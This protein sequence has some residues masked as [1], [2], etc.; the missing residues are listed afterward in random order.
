MGKGWAADAT[1]SVLDVQSEVDGHLKEAELGRG[2]YSKY[3]R[4][5]KIYLT[6]VV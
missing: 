1:V 3:I 4:I 2:I 6:S 5:H